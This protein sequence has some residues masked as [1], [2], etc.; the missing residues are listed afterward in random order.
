MATH[1]LG[2]SFVFE[3]RGLPVV[4]QVSGSLSL[5]NEGVTV[6]NNC[7][8]DWGV[9]LAGGDKSGSFSFTG[10]IDFGSDPASA[11]SWFDLYADLGSVQECIF[12][13]KTVGQKYLTFDAQ[14]N[15]LELTAE[16]NTQV[17]FS[18]TFDISGPPTVVTAA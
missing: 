18:A 6:R 11:Y 3:W 8:G 14:L 13:D 16:R 2:K 12:G 7:S 10:D 1:K 17:S 9:R 5:T 4:C 15:G